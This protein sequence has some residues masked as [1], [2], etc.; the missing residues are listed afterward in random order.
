VKVAVTFATPQEFAK[1]RQ[2]AGFRLMRNSGPV[3][4]VR[5]GEHDLVAIVTGIGNRQIRYGS[6]LIRTCDVCIASGLAGA[7]KSNFSP[8][9]IL[10]ARAVK[11]NA[12]QDVISSDEALVDAAVRCGARP[13]DFFYTAATV[14]DSEEKRGIAATA[15]AV[16]MESFEILSEASRAGVP[17]VAVRSISES[18]GE[19]LPLDFNKVIDPKG[20]IRWSA[21]AGQLLR[22][23]VRIRAFAKF[24]TDSMNAAR[25]L[26]E[27]LDRYVDGL[28]ANVRL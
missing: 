21:M 16:E 14:L 13:V 28:P 3:F 5:K 8:G 7:L 20:Q 27:F 17:A 18:S 15:E 6:T 11:G 23:P 22:S 4:Q 19:S 10:V 26:A 12:G 24:A 25:N 1:W 2:R 9:E